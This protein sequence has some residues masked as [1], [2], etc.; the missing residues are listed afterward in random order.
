MPRGHRPP[1]TP[2]SKEVMLMAKS[3]P[4]VVDKVG[5]A[6]VQEQTG[7]VIGEDGRF[8]QVRVQIKE[9]FTCTVGGRHYVFRK[10]EVR[11]I[12][13]D[14]YAVLRRNNAVY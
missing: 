1:G 6:R 9:D 4:K 14:V 8:F 5:E 10:N 7:A 12:P 13:N 11:V 2:K 3:E